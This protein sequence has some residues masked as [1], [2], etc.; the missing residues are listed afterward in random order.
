[1]L[2]KHL[3]VSSRCTHIKAHG[4]AKLAV[5]EVRGHLPHNRFVPS[6]PALDDRPHLGGLRVAVV[7]M[8]N[9]IT[10][11]KSD[12]AELSHQSPR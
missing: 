4:G 11:L 12:V 10:A 8:R 6:R 5:R 3:P 1:M 9:Q 2:G 7:T